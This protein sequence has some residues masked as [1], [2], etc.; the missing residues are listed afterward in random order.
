MGLGR[1]HLCYLLELLPLGMLK[2]LKRF[3]IKKFRFSEKCTYTDTVKQF[4][5]FI[6]V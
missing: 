3:R 2:R 4:Y 1:F 5:N 6:N